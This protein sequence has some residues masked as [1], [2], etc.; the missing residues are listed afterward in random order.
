MTDLKI[1]SLL[2]ATL[3][4]YAGGKIILKTYQNKI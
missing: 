1:A 2:L 4:N 3:I